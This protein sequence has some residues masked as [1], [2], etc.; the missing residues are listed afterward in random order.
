MPS[1]LTDAVVANMRPRKDQSAWKDIS[2]GACRGLCLR[3][4]PQGEK[5]WA[6]RL[7]VGGRRVRHTLGAWPTLG[8]GKAR[9]RA[10]E[11]LSAARECTLPAQVDA[12]LKAASLTVTAAHADYL[13]AMA[14]A[15]REGT[16]RRKRDMF[17][18][19]IGPEIG[20]RVVGTIRKV[21]I[22][23][24]VESVT[25]KGYRVQANRVYSEVMAFLRWC[26]QKDYV[27]GVP[28][29]RRKDVRKVGAAKEV[30]RDRTLSDSELR[31]V[32]GLTGSMGPLTGDFARLLLLTGQRLD[33]VRE[34]TWTEIDLEAATWTIPGTRYKTGRDHVVPLSSATLAIL[35]ARWVEGAAGY[36]LAG[37]KEGQA[38]NGHA[39]A[40]KRLRKK[41]GLD[42]QAAD[43]FT[44]H[45]FRRTVR[46][47]MSR[48]GVDDRTA[49]MVL[50]HLPQGIVRTY[51]RYN[52]LAEK[53]EALEKW[54]VHV[55]R[56][57]GQI[58][59]ESNRIGGLSVSNPPI[60]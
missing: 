60:A 15:I 57:T 7:D 56:I 1:V 50:G 16:V 18:Q 42:D 41:M 6:I 45:D 28:S 17:A 46:S 5:V 53:R 47:G 38:F 44:W 58:L 25:A 36:V 4:S 33:E 9:E 24:V 11:Y 31:A 19:H 12:R 3:I 14:S 40:M 26:E 52:R 48:L 27:A 43:V 37:T 30:A 20:K 2:D 35:K 10:R 22:V 21:D 32:W 51:D 34:M 49:E 55:Q 13:S 39:S 29:L 54:A 8:L 23:S 59:I